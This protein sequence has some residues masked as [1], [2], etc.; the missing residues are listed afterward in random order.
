M[1]AAAPRSTTTELRAYG[2]TQSLRK[3]RESVKSHLRA[4]ELDALEFDAGA[5]TPVDQLTVRATELALQHKVAAVILKLGTRKRSANEENDT[6]IWAAWV[7][8]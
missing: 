5:A 3:A 2:L 4:D 7:V 8:L 6:Q 1:A